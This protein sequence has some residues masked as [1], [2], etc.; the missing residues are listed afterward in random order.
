MAKDPVNNVRS[1]TIRR[2]GIGTDVNGPSDEFLTPVTIVANGVAR[3]LNNNGTVISEVRGD[4]RHFMPVQAST[5]AP[6]AAGQFFIVTV[7][8]VD[9]FAFVDSSNTLVLIAPAG[10]ALIGT[11]ALVNGVATT[12]D[13]VAN[14]GIVKW[15]VD[16]DDGAGAH[17]GFEVVSAPTAAGTNDYIITGLTSPL[18]HTVAVDRTASTTTLDITASGAGY[19]ATVRRTE[20]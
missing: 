10:G 4:G 20:M 17:Q 3:R 5:P 11:T 9:Y 7:A 14:S 13:T 2:V 15:W 8:S 16:I 6:L 18:T 19:S 1:Q 12:V